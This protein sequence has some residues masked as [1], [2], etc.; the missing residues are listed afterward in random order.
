M[1]TLDW[2]CGPMGGSRPRAGVDSVT[3]WHPM[4]YVESR[5]GSLWARCCFPLE[6]RVVVVEKTLFSLCIVKSK[7]SIG[8][9][10]QI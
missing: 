6:G 7:K 5:L 4:R 8:F 10:K 2:K 1:A 9:C 3:G